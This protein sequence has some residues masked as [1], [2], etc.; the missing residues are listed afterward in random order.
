MAKKIKLTALEQQVLGALKQ[1][2]DDCSGGDFAILGQMR[3][4]YAAMHL[5]G[6]QFGGV[7]TSLQEKGV[8]EVHEPTEVNGG[9]RYA[10]QLTQ[11]TF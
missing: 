11:I 4:Y 3:P 2:A 1:Q 7:L 9:T 6:Q 10:E 8:I 5:T